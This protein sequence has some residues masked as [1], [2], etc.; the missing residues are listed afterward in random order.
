MGEEPESGDPSVILLTPGP[1][2]TSETVR[3]AGA[4]PDLNHRDP[5]YLAMV[6]EI[7]QRL[8]TVENGFAG[9]T[10][11]LLGG[12]GTAAVEAMITSCIKKGPCLILANGYYSERLHAIFDIYDIPHKTLRWDWLSPWS[13]DQ[14]EAEL[15]SGGYEAVLGTHNETTTGRLNDI[16]RLGA[17]CRQV[18][19]K[20]LIDAMS[21]FGADSIDPTNLDAVCASA[22]KC[23]HGIPGVGFVLSNLDISS[24]PRRSYYLS[25]PM[26]SGDS[27]P[28]TPP[29]PAMS[30]FRQALRERSADRPAQYAERAE[31]VRQELARRGFDAVIP[32]SETSVTV[33]TYR[34]PEGWTAS[35]WLVANRERGFVLYGCKG[36]LAANCFQ[37]S[38]MGEVTMAH[39]A[40]WIR[41]VD[42]LTHS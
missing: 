20:C 23:L 26:Y 1:C 24:V 14:I 12:S 31:F 39:L 38:V 30:A 42:E 10:P 6:A 32:A 11:Y 29:V 2:M 37:V 15:R 19:A 34:V 41:V 40:A 7:K 5:E 25:L 8:L 35:N 18:G 17:L 3:L 13:F 9:W 16:S 33:T 4:A 21:S 36:E 27:P 22:N 28:L